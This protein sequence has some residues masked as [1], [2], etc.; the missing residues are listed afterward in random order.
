MSN[1]TEKKVIPSPEAVM[2]AYS[3]ADE[4][5]KLSVPE[6]AL[7]CLEKYEFEFIATLARH[8][9]V[10]EARLEKA[11]KIAERDQYQTGAVA[12][13]AVQSILSILS[14]SRS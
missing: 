13:A 8:S 11:R 6:R 7:S 4:M 14:G 9:R 10:L 2:E 1:M 12:R 3:W 5:S